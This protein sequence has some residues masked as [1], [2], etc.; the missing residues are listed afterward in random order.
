MSTE[1]GEYQSTELGEYQYLGDVIT[2]QLKLVHSFYLLKL[3]VFIK[4]TD[5][6][7]INGILTG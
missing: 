5:L 1:L 6:A 4:V 2:G 3:P 7:F